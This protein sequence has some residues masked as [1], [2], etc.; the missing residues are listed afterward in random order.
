M[1][2][3]VD[4]RELGVGT[5]GTIRVRIKNQQLPRNKLGPQG[6]RLCSAPWSLV[7][8]DVL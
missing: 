6:N 5:E 4:V 1:A 2:A 7:D 3:W 8:L